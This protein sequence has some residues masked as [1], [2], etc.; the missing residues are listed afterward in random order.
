[1]LEILLIGF[2]SILALMILSRS[3]LKLSKEYIHVTNSIKYIE[4]ENTFCDRSYDIVYKDRIVSFSAE[5]YKPG[6]EELETIKRDFVKLTISLMGPTLY[7]YLLDFYGDDEAMTN[8][9]LTW[10]NAR[11]DS[12][13]I[14]ELAENQIK[15]DADMN[16]PS[17]SMPTDIDFSEQE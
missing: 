7:H 3:I 6:G 9:L 15:G 17:L 16:D 8:S 14:M 12:D 2:G 4:L 11:L 13:E 5:G 10:F 1:M